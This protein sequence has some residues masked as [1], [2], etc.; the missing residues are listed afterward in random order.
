MVCFD[1]LRS[2][3]SPLSSACQ[4]MNEVN[5]RGNVHQTVVSVAPVGQQ[6]QSMNR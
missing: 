5:S 3:F 1:L 4:M 2:S 6:P